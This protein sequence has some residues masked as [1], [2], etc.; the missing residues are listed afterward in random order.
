MALYTISITL[1][2][3]ADS[4]GDAERIAN[5]INVTG[6]Y[7]A[8]YINHDSISIEVELEPEQ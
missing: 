5:G 6:G 7:K 2:V 4:Q 8:D 1:Y 3:D